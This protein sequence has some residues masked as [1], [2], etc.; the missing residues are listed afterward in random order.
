MTDHAPSHFVQLLPVML[1]CFM[2]LFSL[3]LVSAGGPSWYLE[4]TLG[5]VVGFGLSVL[6]SRRCS[7][8]L[9][10]LSLSPYL[11]AAALGVIWLYALYWIYPAP[12]AR[13]LM[14]LSSFVFPVLYLPFFTRYPQSGRYV[15]RWGCSACSGRCTCR[16]LSSG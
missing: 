10:L 8:S 6:A 2:A 4:V 14:L 3:V 11:H 12:L 5:L 7:W 9:R 16:T 13:D 1:T 15:T